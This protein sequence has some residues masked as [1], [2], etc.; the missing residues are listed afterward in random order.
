MNAFFHS[1]FVC[2]V[3]LTVAQPLVAQNRVD[4]VLQWEAEPAQPGQF[5]WVQKSQ[6]DQMTLTANEAFFPR[7]GLKAEGQG[8]VADVANLNG[9][10]SFASIS[11]W[12]RSSA[13]EWG[14]WLT[15]GNVTVQITIDASTADAFDVVIDRN[16]VVMT[17]Q[18]TGSI[19]LK[20]AGRH[21]VIV[22]CRQPSARLKLD[23]VQLKHV[24][25]G[26]GIIRKRWRP[27]AAH[28]KFRSSKNPTDVRMWIME[29]DAEPGDLGFYSPMTTPFGYYG[30]TWRSD[31]TVNS[32]F[33]FSLWSYGRNQPEPPMQELSHLL[34]IGH[35]DATFGKFGHEG[36]GVKIRDWEPLA[37][38]QG[39]RQAFALRVQ[40][41][42]EYDTYFS[43][44]YSTKERRW[45]F[46]GAGRKYNKKKPLDSL[47]V[48]S[49]VEVP[50][51]PTVQRTG[52]YARR[53]NYRGWVVDANGNTLALDTM[54]NGN[55]DQTSGYTH[56]NRGVT[57]NG[58]CFLETGGWTF[59][60]PPNN[61][62]DIVMAA[63]ASAETPDYLTAANLKT[64]Q[65]VPCEIAITQF[66]R[67][68][69]KATLQFNLQAGDLLSDVVAYWGAKDGLTF[70]EAWQFNNN[71]SQFLSG[72][73]QVT[74]SGVDADSPMFVRLFAR[75]NLG[76]YWSADA[77]RAAAP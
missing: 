55:V 25:A 57:D 28:T 22:R 1:M 53:M 50:G 39:Q 19:Y 36:T 41:G 14:I 8:D 23:S 70:S 24:P 35:P 40:P 37:G 38:Q 11:G 61:G 77:A 65:S 54:T 72:S 42:P 47:W 12:S 32:G 26:S 43:Y 34:A 52:A 20:E 31:G 71:A 64:L 67:N 68:G 51:P 16:E 48:G 63:V 5:Y 75:N 33:N 59:R 6:E 27:A 18:Q 58:W 60:A 45:R 21:S 13:A 4:S 73:H 44:F 7:L 74:L 62:A 46:F 29:M 15:E 76:Q 30:P 17:K 9:G 66:I 3:W 2:C 10:K 69:D 56:T 49:F